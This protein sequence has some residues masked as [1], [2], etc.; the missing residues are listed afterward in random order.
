MRIEKVNDNQIKCTLTREDFEERNLKISEL[1]Y[2]TEK[3]KKLFKEVMQQ[4]QYEYGFEAD[5]IPLMI[6][7]IPMSTGCVVF[8]ITKVEDPEELDTRFSRFAPSVHDSDDDED[9]ENISDVMVDA[10][11]GQKQDNP[12]NGEDP[13]NVNDLLKKIF[14]AASKGAEAINDNNARKNRN[15]SDESKNQSDSAISSLKVYSFIDMDSLVKACKMMNAGYAGESSLFKN[16]ETGKLYLVL[17]SGDFGNPEA[18]GMCNMLKE[19]GDLEPSSSVLIA[20]IEEHY[21]HIIEDKAVQ[22]LSLL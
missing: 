4:A 8:I 21:D 5:N 3:A 20:Y 18:V 10:I 12:Y 7:A 11:A 1:A 22:K 16:V 13:I 6:E 17:V 19:Y 15:S 2:G 9:D 14:K